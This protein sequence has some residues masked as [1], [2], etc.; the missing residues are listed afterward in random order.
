MGGA[1]TGIG[2]TNPLTKSGGYSE[3]KLQYNQPLISHF[4]LTDS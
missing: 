1:T 2:G 3:Y 4:S